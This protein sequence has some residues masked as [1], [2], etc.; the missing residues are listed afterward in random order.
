M[1][2]PMSASFLFVTVTLVW[3]VENLHS[4]RFCRVHSTIVLFHNRH[5]GLEWGKITLSSVLPTGNLVDGLRASSVS[6]EP[7]RCF[8]L[9]SEVTS[10]YLLLM[11]SAFCRDVQVGMLKERTG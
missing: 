3:S 10:L 1:T 7:G 2:Q 4:S 9:A 11:T 8:P 6:E 5:S